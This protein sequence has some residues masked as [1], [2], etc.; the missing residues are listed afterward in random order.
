M[1]IFLSVLSIIFS[2]LSIWGSVYFAIL[3]KRKRVFNN[4]IY[5][6]K[7]H[8]A[9]EKIT[10]EFLNNFLNEY[11]LMYI[12]NIESNYLIKAIIDYKT[13]YIYSN[14]MLKL[15]NEYK[16]IMDRKKWVERCSRIKKIYN[17]K[18]NLCNYFKEGMTFNGI[19]IK[20][21]KK[22]DKEIIKDVKSFLEDDFIRNLLPN[23]SVN[24]HDYFIKYYNEKK[25]ADNVVFSNDSFLENLNDIIVKSSD[26]YNLWNE[27]KLSKSKLVLNKEKTTIKDLFFLDFKLWCKKHKI[28]L[29]SKKKK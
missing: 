25:Y 29:I 15:E 3:N 23:L 28:G 22:S 7:R 5:F 10:Q 21:K 14:E 2:I 18:D 6:Y 16:D 19:L 11:D 13:Y 1:S 20:G 27:I 24:N 26:V 9:N 17:D 12:D 4:Y 8:E